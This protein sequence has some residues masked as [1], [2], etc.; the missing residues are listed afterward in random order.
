MLC[1]VQRPLHSAKIT[2]LPSATWKALGCRVSCRWHSEQRPPLSSVWANDAPQSR[3]LCWVLDLDTWQSR[4]HGGTHRH[5]DFSLPSVRLALGKGFAE[6]PI[7]C[8]WQRGLCRSTVY[9]AP[10][11]E[12]NSQQTICRVYIGLCRVPEALGKEAAS[13]S[14]LLGD[15][16][17]QTEQL[18]VICIVG[19]GGS[20]K[21]TLADAVY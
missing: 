21:S 15:I 7:K 16:K 8:T 3:D 5:G 4:R 6:C 12:C 11:A 17:G 20:G 9:R 19:F 1:R 2:Y 18:R 10:F 14:D 13:G